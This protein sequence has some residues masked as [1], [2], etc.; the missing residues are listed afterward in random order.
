MRVMVIISPIKWCIGK[1]LSSSIRSYSSTSIAHSHNNN[2]H[3]STYLPA[4]DF[5][6]VEFQ[7]I[8]KVPIPEKDQK[9]ID[10]LDR[11][12]Y[13]QATWDIR[14]FCHKC[15][16]NKVFVPKRICDHGGEK[17]GDKGDSVSGVNLNVNEGGGLKGLKRKEEEGSHSQSR[18]L[19]TLGFDDNQPGASLEMRAGSR[20][21]PG[22]YY[23]SCR[24]LEIIGFFFLYC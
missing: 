13:E 5:W 16:S 18:S 4:V 6:I 2:I 10:L 14:A 23:S 11:N 15:A 7:N 20:E 12:G 22:G 21:W 19:L 3:V 9:I 17:G 8:D 1:P 24:S